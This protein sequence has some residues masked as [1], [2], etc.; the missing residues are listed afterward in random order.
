MLLS[1]ALRL[2]PAPR[3]AFTGAGGKTSAMVALGRE[4]L[5]AGTPTVLLT[6]TT[7]MAVDQAGLA[8]H[9][10]LIKGP[11]DIDVYHA[12]IPSGVVLFT[13]PQGD[14]E[15]LS[16]LSPETLEHLHHLAN[17]RSLPLL[18][19]ADGS[20]RR[21][22]KAPA[23]H[24][25]L[26]PPWVETVVVVAGLRGLGKPLTEAWV[27][28]PE[29][30]AS[31]S[32][33][34]PGAPITPDALGRLLCSEAGGLKGIPPGARRVALLNCGVSADEGHLPAQAGSLATH[35]LGPYQAVLA[36]ALVPTSSPAVAPPPNA[37]SS[38]LAVYEPVAGILLAGGASSRMGQAKQT[39]PWRGE[40]LVRH[41]ARAALDAGLSPLVVVTGHAAPEVEAALSGLPVLWSHNPAW[42]IGQSTSVK[43]GVI[44]LPPDTGAAVFLLADQPRVT[45]ALVRSL[46]ESHAAT[47]SPIV[48]PLIDGRRA[49]PVLFDR[50]TFP[51]LLSLQGDSGGRALFSR[52]PVRWALWHDPRL[53]LD[54]DTPEDYQRLLSEG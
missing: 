3:L 47:L 41:V 17:E 39:L 2:G 53:A 30:F 24:E 48:A 19:E 22:L 51:G 9:H 33:L 20:R 52:Y 44:A 46:V 12:G 26:V 15:R 23:A 38:V 14:E 37:A 13:G 7:H 43:A 10:I 49:N 29:I 8:D 36:A 21:P 45:P 35:L 27:H 34:S 54:V 25:P 32:G 18:V 31:L 11:H 4:F 40:A 28:R 6:A 16:G 5:L 42:E 50:Q 1:T